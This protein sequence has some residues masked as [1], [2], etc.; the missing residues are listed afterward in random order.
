MNPSAHF[1]LNPSCAAYN[2]RGAGTVTVHS[3]KDRRYRCTACGKTF[4]ATAGTV[5]ALAARVVACAA[6]CAFLVCVDGFHA[7]ADVFTAAVRAP[8]RTGRPGRPRLVA[9]AGFLLA[10]VV[11]QRTGRVVTAV[12]R[13]I[14]R[15]T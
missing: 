9:P 14:V 15:G 11:K 7:H 3:R 2:A 5:A 13:R 1:C 10:R 12:E 8:L 4:A 6:A